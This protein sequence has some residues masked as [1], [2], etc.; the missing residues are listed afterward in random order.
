MKIE[1]IIKNKDYKTYKKLNEMRGRG[2][3]SGLYDEKN[4]KS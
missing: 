3:S 4:F 1:D 2:A